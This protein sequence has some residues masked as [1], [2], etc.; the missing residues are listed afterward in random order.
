MSMKFVNVNRGFEAR[1]VHATAYGQYAA[2]SR[3]LIAS[4]I[5]GMER[6]AM[7]PIY[8]IAEGAMAELR[9]SRAEALMPAAASVRRKPKLALG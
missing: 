3:S 8:D 5:Q 4:V 1:C 7:W 9:L 6:G 2:F